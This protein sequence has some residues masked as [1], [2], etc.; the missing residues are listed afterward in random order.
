M[1]FYKYNDKLFAFDIK[2]M[3]TYVYEENWKLSFVS[4]HAIELAD[5]NLVELDSDYA[6]SISDASILKMAEKFRKI[7]GDCYVGR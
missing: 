4:I 7:L 2:T 5:Q 6:I 3:L 1:K